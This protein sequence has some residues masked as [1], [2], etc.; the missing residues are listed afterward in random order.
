MGAGGRTATRAS[1][2]G[3]HDVLRRRDL[4]EPREHEVSDLLT[5]LLHDREV[6]AVPCS[7][8]LSLESEDH[9]MRS[10]VEYAHCARWP[11]VERG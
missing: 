1:I 6:V 5:P 9:A 8:T 2:A 3:S 11:P 4:V 10:C 7:N